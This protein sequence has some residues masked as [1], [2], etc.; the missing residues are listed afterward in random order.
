ML[1]SRRDG[2]TWDQRGGAVERVAALGEHCG[3]WVCAGDGGGERKGMCSGTRGMCSLGNLDGEGRRGRCEGR[4]RE[5]VHV[6]I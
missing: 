4:G 2:G 1:G 5:K 6:W 3:G